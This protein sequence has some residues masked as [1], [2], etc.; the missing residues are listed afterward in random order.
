MVKVIYRRNTNITGQSNAE[1]RWSTRPFGEGYEGT[2]KK[3]LAHTG[4]SGDPVKAREKGTGLSYAEHD[5]QRGLDGATEDTMK[6][7]FHTVESFGDTIMA[8]CSFWI[9]AGG[10]VL[11]LPGSSI[12]SE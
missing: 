10:K 5:V 2:A 7:K 11:A 8:T 6:G 12:I 1:K 9:A 4:V 3:C